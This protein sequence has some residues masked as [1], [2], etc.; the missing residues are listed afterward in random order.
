MRGASIGRHARR[1][2]SQS[3]C[4]ARWFLGNSA[5]RFLQHNCR[6]Y[7]LTAS[8]AERVLC[9][10]FSIAERDRHF[11]CFVGMSCFNVCRIYRLS[12]QVN[13]RYGKRLRTF[14]TLQP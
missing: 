11:L 12:I 7:V 5:A 4:C 1:S 2:P 6:L 14:P 9:A 13:N 8:I 10:A 3:V